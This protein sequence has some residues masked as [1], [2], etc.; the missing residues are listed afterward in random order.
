VANHPPVHLT[1]NRNVFAKRCYHRSRILHSNS[2]VFDLSNPALETHLRN[3]IENID[4]SSLHPNQRAMLIHLTA[5]RKA[6]QDDVRQLE[7]EISKGVYS[8]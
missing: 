2:G 6:L 3:T 5:T 7:N 8:N 1:S 4:S